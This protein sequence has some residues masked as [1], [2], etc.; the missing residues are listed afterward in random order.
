M[1]ITLALDLLTVHIR[2]QELAHQVPNNGLV[3]VTQALHRVHWVRDLFFA[4][5]GHH[6]RLA[7]GG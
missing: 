7:L 1:K 2:H 6:K 3:I 5:I 4:N